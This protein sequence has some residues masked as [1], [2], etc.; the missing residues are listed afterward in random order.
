[1]KK[2]KSHETYRGPA[3][4]VDCGVIRPDKRSLNLA[5]METNPELSVVYTPIACFLSQK[6]GKLQV[7]LCSQNTQLQLLDS[8]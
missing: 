7:V 2:S 5:I 8:H 3:L 6:L 4:V 1:M